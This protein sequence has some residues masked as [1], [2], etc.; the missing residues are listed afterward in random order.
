MK[1]IMCKGLP[2]SGKSTWAREQIGFKRINK[3]DLR[4][5]LDNSVWSKQNEKFILVARDILIHHAL[6]Q[7][8]SIISDDTNLA[9]KHEETLRN[10]AKQ[11]K[12]EFI[13]QDFTD[14]PIEV[15]IERDLKRFDSVGERVIRKQARDFLFPKETNRVVPL[16]PNPALP[17]AIICDIDGTLAL[18]GGANPYNRDFSEDWVNLPIVSILDSYI[19]SYKIILVSGRKDTYREVTE[20]W[21]VDNDIHYDY[22]FMR[23]GDDN[24][25]DFI[26]KQE[27]YEAEIKDKYNI[28]FVLD[29]RNQVVEL[30]RSLG[31]TCLQVA[32]G[33]F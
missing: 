32:E 2:G 3:D 30:W 10:I 16:S 5:M 22:L 23:K 7:G 11:Y 18:F 17:D 9:P 14:V 28:L 27:I 33:D 6:S 21:L 4:K 31:L 26:I 29:D 12:A 20:R 1:L 15:C 25:K 24:R 8:I 19:S 13:V